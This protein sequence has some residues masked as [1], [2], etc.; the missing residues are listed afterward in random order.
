MSDAVDQRHFRPGREPQGAHV[1]GFFGIEPHLFTDSTTGQL[2]SEECGNRHRTWRRVRAAHLRGARD[3]QDFEGSRRFIA[4]HFTGQPIR[5]ASL[6]GMHA[7][8]DCRA[9]GR[10]PNILRPP[11]FR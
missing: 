9:L 4:R 1:P 10:L 2:G 3:R 6:S 5:R 11:P 8:R 7:D